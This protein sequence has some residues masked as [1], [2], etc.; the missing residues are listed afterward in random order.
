MT[1]GFNS[2][3]T[4]HS[5][6]W[7]Q[8]AISSMPRIADKDV[9]LHAFFLVWVQRNVPW[10]WEGQ[11]PVDLS[12]TDHEGLRQSL[13]EGTV[14]SSLSEVKLATWWDR[15]IDAANRLKGWKIKLLPAVMHIPIPLPTYVRNDFML[16]ADFRAVEAK[17]HAILQSSNA[18]ADVHSLFVFSLVVFAGVTSVPLLDVILRSKLSRVHFCAG[19]IFVSL[20]IPLG[21]GQSTHSTWF[22]DRMTS[23]LL[24]RWLEQV[25]EAQGVQVTE[26]VRTTDVDTPKQR[27]AKA[28]QGAFAHLKLPEMPWQDFLHAAHVAT[29]LHVS[30]FLAHFLHGTFASRSMHPAV[31]QRLNGWVVDEA[32]EA[33]DRAQLA[34]FVP[35][36]H[37]NEECLQP[38]PLPFDPLQIPVNQLRFIKGIKNILV[39]TKNAT[40]AHK[41]LT[42]SIRRAH[43]VLWPITELLAKWVAWRLGSSED[44]GEVAPHF[45]T[46]ATSSALRYL[47]AIARHLITELGPEDVRELEPE[48]FE[49]LYEEAGAC[50]KTEKERPV[51]WM[52]VSAFHEYLM[53]F[54]APEIDMDDLDGYEGA[55]AATGAAN[56]V[57]EREFQYFK[58]EVMGSDRPELDSQRLLWMLVAVL[59]FRGGLRRRE[60]QMLWMHDF[61]P[62]D[63]P[64]LNVRAS[65]LAT[66]KSKSSRRRIPLW[67]LLATDEL[68][69]FKKYWKARS[70]STLTVNGL[71]FSSANTPSTPLAQS[72]LF[73][74][75]TQAFGRLV[76]EVGPRFRFHCL[77]HAFANWTLLKLVV[78]DNPDW[79]ANLPVSCV[80]DP[81]VYAK[82][83]KALKDAAFPHLAQ[84]QEAP[85]RRYLYLVSALLGHLSPNTTVRYYI[86]ILGLLSRLELNAALSRRLHHW[87]HKE[88]ANAC[89]LSYSATTKGTYKFS[90]ET[91]LDFLGKFAEVHVHRSQHAVVASPD[92]KLDLTD[93]FVTKWSPVIP[94]PSQL[95]VLLTL[96]IRLEEQLRHL[97]EPDLESRMHESMLT[98]L[99]Q[100]HGISTHC[101]ELAY[102]AYQFIYSP[103]GQ[104]VVAPR[105]GHE[106]PAIPSH[107]KE[108]SDFWRIL[109]QTQSSWLDG[110]KRAAMLVAATR[111][112]RRVGYNTSE[113]G[114]GEHAGEMKAIAQGLI[115]FGI[116]VDQL[117]LT[118][119]KEALPDSMVRKHVEASQ[120]FTKAAMDASSLGISV[121]HVP[122][123]TRQRHRQSQNL[124]LRITQTRGST[125]SGAKGKK[126]ASPVAHL[127]SVGHAVVRGL[128]YAAVWVLFAAS[129]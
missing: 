44:R 67:A 74:P 99:G 7:P 33:Q 16:L 35:A 123:P 102:G 53:F 51:F 91:P 75:I 38:G 21:Q 37:L 108:K 79:V 48:D 68:E 23:A 2:S 93:A 117:C 82:H 14:R 18:K 3:A 11:C 6:A 31:Y 98:T 103:R 77:R 27:V 115:A 85:S 125:Q 128:N 56:V 34:E 24:L 60:V 129:I 106:Y 52:C 20:D 78:A 5:Q 64:V 46:L 50:V 73:D 57:S 45:K 126:G 127:P 72:V 32:Y 22:P 87:S 113:L 76:G 71:L 15:L 59:G 119:A 90:R 42:A 10:L 12:K 63:F 121:D 110:S 107:S 28:V 95:L 39:K 40:D 36:P 54:G 120:V 124:M 122:R 89:G 104:E 41:E 55:R 25:D 100:R 97:M 112:S 47:N 84:T 111:W 114:L 88:I 49:T 62:G 70:E 81:V 80:D 94:S 116:G 66:L 13:L 58:R 105:M 86:S 1:Q 17:F 8:W 109:D 29:S 26:V 43:G 101:L 9:D 69:W 83:A 4:P 30:P 118:V 65:R 19:D 61:H 96:R 92:I